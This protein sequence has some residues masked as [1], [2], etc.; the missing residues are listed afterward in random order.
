MPLNGNMSG[1]FFLCFF[2]HLYR[3][4]KNAFRVFVVVGGVFVFYL[5]VCL[6]FYVF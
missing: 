4:I 1:F 6:F 3:Q 2:S 5:F